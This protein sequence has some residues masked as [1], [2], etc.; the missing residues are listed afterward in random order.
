MFLPVAVYLHFL[1][2]L[3]AKQLHS[4]DNNASS[5]QHDFLRTDRLYRYSDSEKCPHKLDQLRASLTPIEEK[6]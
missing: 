6:N 1:P 3:S 4:K 5:E 2:R